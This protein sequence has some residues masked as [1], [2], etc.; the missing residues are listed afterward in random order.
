VDVPGALAAR[1]YATDVDL[2]I[3]VADDL[4]PENAGRWRLTGSATRAHCT[5][6]MDEPDL[7]C[8]VRALGAAYLGGTPLGALADAAAVRE[9]TPGAV[10]AASAAFGWHRTPSC[11]EVF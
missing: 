3:E 10:S 1:R 7:A 4:V 2:V 6:T 9:L 5:S 8:D 11:V